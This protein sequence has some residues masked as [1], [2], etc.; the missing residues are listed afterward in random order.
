[1]SQRGHCSFSCLREYT[2]GPEAF[3]Y[4][5]LGSSEVFCQELCY[6]LLVYILLLFSMLFPPPFNI[7]RKLDE[8]F[9]D[10]DSIMKLC[11]T[12]QLE[13]VLPVNN[14]SSNCF[15]GF[16]LLVWFQQS[17]KGRKLSTGGLRHQLIPETVMLN[18]GLGYGFVYKIMQ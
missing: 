10:T 9:S 1:M 14:F 13:L 5:L 17:N 3:W 11:R 16:L 8:C 2:E 12:F 6:M 15:V 4:V 18:P 7:R